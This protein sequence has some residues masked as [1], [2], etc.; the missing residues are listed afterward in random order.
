MGKF[1][2]LCKGCTKRGNC[3]VVPELRQK[4]ADEI[5]LMLHHLLQPGAFNAPRLE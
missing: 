2:I 5:S 4:V 3:I 1:L